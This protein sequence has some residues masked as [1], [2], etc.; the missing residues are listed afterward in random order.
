MPVSQVSSY[1]TQPAN[2]LLI[3]VEVRAACPGLVLLVRYGALPGRTYHALTSP[4]RAEL[5]ALYSYLRGL[6]PSHS[7]IAAA[8]QRRRS[9]SLAA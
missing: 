5:F 4:K 1:D 7:S 3:T 8:G 6:F 2:R 9:S